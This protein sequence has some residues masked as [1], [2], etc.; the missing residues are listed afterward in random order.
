MKHVPAPPE[1]PDRPRDLGE[2]RRRLAGRLSD[3]REGWRRCDNRLCR[4]LRRCAS[5]Q[6]EC[7]A[8]RRASLPPAS[9]EELAARRQ[10]LRLQLEVRKRF[11][12]GPV[13]VELLR[14]AI[15]REKA[16]REAAM[17]P[18]SADAAVAEAPKLSPDKQA[19]IDRAWNDYVAEQEKPM[20]EKGPRITQL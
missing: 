19:R 9:S 5:E 13:S 15:D 7:I 10:E 16:A 17:L 1:D 11:G 8:K 6:R 4:R 18:R 3:S 20:R 14:E 12:D 2:L